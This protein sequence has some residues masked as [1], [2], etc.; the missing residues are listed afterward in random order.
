[1]TAKVILSKNGHEMLADILKQEINDAAGR[2]ALEYACGRYSLAESLR[3]ELDYIACTDKSAELLETLKDKAG[4]KGI[5]L[6]PDDELS[7]DCYFGR[8]HIVYTIFGFQGISHPVDEILRL[9]RLLI[10]GG[11]III[12]DFSEN[13]F[14]EECIKQLKRCGFSDI[15]V[16]AFLSDDKPAFK[17]TAVK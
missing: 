4:E 2:K 15:A 14:Q 6:I 9:R 5:Y 3:D 17:I 11:K 7:E 8:F 10:K 13:A 1:M 16:T 12:I